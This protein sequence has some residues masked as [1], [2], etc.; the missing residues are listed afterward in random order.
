MIN[1]SAS[2]SKNDNS[3][4]I[5]FS[6]IHIDNETIAKFIKNMIWFY[7]IKRKNTKKIEFLFFFHQ[8]I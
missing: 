5:D 8:F 2:I 1:E 4:N 6:A 3:N 7:L